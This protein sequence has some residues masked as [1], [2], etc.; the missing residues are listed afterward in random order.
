M[1]NSAL[2]VWSETQSKLKGFIYRHTKDK[3]V[4]DDIAQDVFLKVHSKLDQLKDVDKLKS[5]IFQITRHSIADHFRSQSKSLEA[6]EIDWE[7]ETRALNECASHCVVEILETLPPKYREALQ[8]SELQSVSQL[9]LAK[10]L[11][12]SY[13]GAKSRVQRARQMLK[14]KM[15]QEYRIEMDKYGNVITC[16]NKVPCNCPTESCDV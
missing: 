1:N 5:W 3:A 16:Q 12:I 11:N 2:M 6:H 15:E 14:E 9:E 7:S 13:S 4:T 10:Q 8:L